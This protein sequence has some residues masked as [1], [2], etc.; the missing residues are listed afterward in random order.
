MNTSKSKIVYGAIP[1]DL[2]H[3]GFKLRARQALAWGMKETGWTKLHIADYLNVSPG[4]V[5]NWLFGKTA[6]PAWAIAAM[7]PIFGPIYVQMVYG[8]YANW[9][10]KRWHDKQAVEREAAR[11][12]SW[13]RTEYGT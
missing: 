12:V 9:M 11:Q 10:L 13:M 3:E 2:Q 8:P 4:T 6:M 7:W 5:D 1:R